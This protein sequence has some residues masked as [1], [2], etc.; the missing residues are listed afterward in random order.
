MGRVRRARREIHHER[1]VRHQ[2]LL[3]A[4]PGDGAI[5]QVLGQRVALLGRLG[6]LHGGRAFI[7]AGKVLVR[8]AA[9]EAVEMFEARAGRPL[10]ERPHGRDLPERH[11]VALAELRRRIAVELQDLRQRR[12]F[13]GPDAV[14]AR[15]RRRHL[16]DRA[17]AD[18]MM[19]PAGEKR[20]AR[21]RAQSG[22]ME[23]VVLEPI[24]RK[25]FGGRACCTVRRTR[26]RRRSRH[27]RGERSRRSARPP[28]GA[29]ARSAGTSYWD[30]WRR[31]S[32]ARHASG[33][34]SARCGEEACH[35]NQPQRSLPFG[36]ASASRASG[37]KCQIRTPSTPPSGQPSNR[38]PRTDASR[39]IKTRMSATDGCSVRLG[40]R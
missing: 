14:V 25:A 34:G 32:S 31:R 26:S 39:L 5:G 16:G 23:P 7:E 2:H 19:V 37:A 33:Q 4:H 11:F 1:L 30:P 17:H 12:L 21:R 28:A 35:L 3:L 38:S 20:L 18:G 13:L 40:A 24:G 6:R 10:V 36:S 27:R 22:R 15:R 9:D 29:A 8:L